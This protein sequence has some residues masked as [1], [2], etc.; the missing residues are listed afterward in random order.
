MR[1][2]QPTKCFVQLQKLRVRLSTYGSFVVVL[3]C[4]FLTFHLTC[5]HIFSWVW[6]AEWPS[7]GK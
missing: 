5:V 3:C 4:Q 6:V 7:F 1:T 2:E